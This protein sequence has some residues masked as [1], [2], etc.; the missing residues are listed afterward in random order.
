[1]KWIPIS[2]AIYLGVF[3][4]YLAQSE[5]IQLLDRWEDEGFLFGM[6]E[7]YI[8]KCGVLFIM[9]RNTE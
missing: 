8:M 1:M 3:T 9:T 2:I 5:R 6:D 4:N 7:L